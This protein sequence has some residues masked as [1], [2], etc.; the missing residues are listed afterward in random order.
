MNGEAVMIL[1]FGRQ[2]SVGNR[3][4]DSTHKNLIGII[5]EISRSIAAR[6]VAAAIRGFEQLENCLCDYFVVEE[7]IA[8]A[9]NFDF[10]NHKLAHQRLLSEF[11]RIKDWLTSENGMWSCEDGE[12]YANSLMHYFIQHIKEDGRQLKIV[13]DTHLYDLKP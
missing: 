8:H 10:A 6:D 13:L 3:V 7:S 5:Q 11:Y 4:I 2:L 1:G 9:V 12:R